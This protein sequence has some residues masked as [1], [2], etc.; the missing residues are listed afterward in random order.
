MSDASCD[1]QAFLGKTKLTKAALL[2]AAEIWRPY[3]YGDSW[4]N[5]AAVADKIRLVN[6]VVH[7]HAEP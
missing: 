2:E 5:K 4:E 7:T 6:M 1:E 3:R